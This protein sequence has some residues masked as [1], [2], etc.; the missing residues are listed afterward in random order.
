MD[1]PHDGCWRTKNKDAFRSGEKL[2][3]KPKFQDSKLRYWQHEYN[4]NFRNQ[5][6]R[7]ESQPSFKTKKIFFFIIVLQKAATRTLQA[8]EP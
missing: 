7:S 6:S 2:L 4:P 3:Q 1:G 5:Q 8:C